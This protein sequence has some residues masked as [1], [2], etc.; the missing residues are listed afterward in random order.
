V[1]DWGGE[2]GGWNFKNKRL[3]WGGPKE[4]VGEWE[5]RKCVKAPSDRSRGR[6]IKG[7]AEIPKAKKKFQGEIKVLVNWESPI[8]YKPAEKTQ[9]K[10]GNIQRDK[11]EGPWT[12]A[13]LGKSGKGKG[14]RRRRH[15]SGFFSVSG[16]ALAL[17]GEFFGAVQKRGKKV[18][19]LEKENRVLPSRPI[20]QGKVQEIGGTTS[21]PAI[22]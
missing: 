10:K 4:K 5:I 1:V 11:K 16:G 18:T 13:G 22:L 12:D 15:Q 17:K 2:R 7:K 20:E 8:P 6:G 14:K 3:V 19:P 9:G 21:G